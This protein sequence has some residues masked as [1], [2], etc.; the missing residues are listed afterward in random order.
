MQYMMVSASHSP[1]LDM[2]PA[3]RERTKN[4][5][6]AL[7][8][9][10]KRIED[11]DPQLVVLFGVDHYGGHQM[12]CMPSFTI[13]VEATSL[14]DVGGTPGPLNV[15]RDVAVSAVEAVRDSGVDVAVSYAMEVD[16]GFS[17]VAMT[18]LG[19]LTRY[20]ILPVFVSCIQPPFVPYKRARAL[21]E[22]I[23]KFTNNLEAYQRVLFLGSG[24]LTHDPAHLYPPI[25]VVSD[26][27]KPYIL[28]GKSQSEVPQQKWI[29]YEIEAHEHGLP[30]LLDESIT[31]S[32]LGLVD[33]WDKKFLETYCSGDMSAFDSWDPKEVM[34]EAG[35]GAVETLSWVAARS[36][37]CSVSDC[38]PRESFYQLTREVGVGFGI[39]EARS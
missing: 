19:S 3:D 20:P 14:A 11:F 1:M 25:D 12:A 2:T 7:E 6:L 33:H 17:Q 18:T 35:I 21:G 8:S 37:I 4:V 15:P 23:G 31:E 26:E 27:W 13:G 16:H 39:V 24:G 10:R 34:A 38:V 29:D 30:I 22:A 5:K 28:H 32:D 9:T 36:A